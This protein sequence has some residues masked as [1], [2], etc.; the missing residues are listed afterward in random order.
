MQFFGTI[1]KVEGTLHMRKKEGRNSQVKPTEGCLLRTDDVGLLTEALKERI[2]VAPINTLVKEI[3][4]YSTNRG[5]IGGAAIAFCKTRKQPP[6]V[7]RLRR[8][9]PVHQGLHSALSNGSAKL[10]HHLGELHGVEITYGD[11][12]LRFAC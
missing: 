4:D 1:Q 11:G 6:K 7:I 12:Q 10:I 8:G 3:E 9:D 2:G 5:R